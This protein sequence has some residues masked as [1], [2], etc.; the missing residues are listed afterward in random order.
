MSLSI[1]DKDSPNPKVQ[2]TL[3]LHLRNLK[4]ADGQPYDLSGA[5]I[6]Y[7]TIKDSLA[8]VDASADAQIDSTNEASQFTTT[9]AS[10]GNLDVEFT[11]TNTDLTAGTPYYVDVKA[12][13]ASGEIEELV[14]DVFIFDTPVTL[15]TS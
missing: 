1:I 15:S 11:P 10:T 6:I 9:Y 4:D 5:S 14:R 7:A 3:T 2:C 13:W 12:I 8:D